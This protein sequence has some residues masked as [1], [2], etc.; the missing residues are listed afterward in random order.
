MTQETRMATLLL[1][2]PDR[3]GLVARIAHF[4]FERGGNIID[5][6]EHVDA[7]EG[8]FFLRVSWDM[9]DFSLAGDEV[10]EAFAPLAKEFQAQWAIKLNPSFIPT[11]LCR[12]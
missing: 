10:A 2:C 8:L 12:R 4:V 5:L 6:D 1:T 7:N 3:R 9:Q 11:G